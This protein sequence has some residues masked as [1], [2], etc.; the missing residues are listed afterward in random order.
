MFDNRTKGAVDKGR[1]GLRSELFGQLN[2][3]VDDDLD[4]SLLFKD[5][6]PKGEAKDRKVSAV[7]FVERPFGSVFLDSR[8]NFLDV[9][10]DGGKIGC[11]GMSRIE[12]PGKQVLNE[13]NSFKMSW[14]VPAFHS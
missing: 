3:F 4:R 14:V 6:L 7:D 11:L 13:A 1:G 2:G 5:Q 12:T 9:G 10:D 8:V